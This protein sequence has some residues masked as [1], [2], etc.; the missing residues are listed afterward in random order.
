[1]F[2][3][4]QYYSAVWVVLVLFLLVGFLLF[5]NKPRLP[6]IVAFA[7][8]V[9]G[10]AALYF[11]FRPVQTEL[12]GEAAEVQ[13]MIGQGKPVL[14]EFQS[15]YC[16]ACIALKPTIDSIEEEFAGR[17]IVLRINA[18]EQA[19]M[20]LAPVYGF[21]YTP[22]F[23]FFDNNGNESW[24]MIGSFDENRLRQELSNR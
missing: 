24:R 4:S 22:T 11:Y 21:Q 1:M 20:Q 6:E 7:A 8:V 15:P 19:G 16:I 14:L 3:G 23:V 17:L 13:A 5:R 10:I 18:Q 12:M 9:V 2:E